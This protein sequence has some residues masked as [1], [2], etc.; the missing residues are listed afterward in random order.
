MQTP[1]PDLIATNLM[2]E[3]QRESEARDLLRKTQRS[4]LPGWFVGFECVVGTVIVIIFYLSG[5]PII[6]S[7]VSGIAFCAVSLAASAIAELRRVNK[8]LE[9]ALVLLHKIEA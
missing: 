6:E 2:H 5:K 4:L 9:A 1:V 8:R 7:I 3:I